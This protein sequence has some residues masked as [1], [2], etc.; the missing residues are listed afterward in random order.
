MKLNLKKTAA[1]VIA[2][3]VFVAALI[4]CNKIENQKGIKNTVI[5]SLENNSV[6]TNDLSW[7][8]DI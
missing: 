2:F 1:G 8:N 3:V 5:S 6:V 7:L 4:Y